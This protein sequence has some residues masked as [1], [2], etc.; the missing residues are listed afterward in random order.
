MQK[1]IL[2]MSRSTRSKT[3]CGR[4]R[5]GCVTPLKL[6]FLPNFHLKIFILTIQQDSKFDCQAALKSISGEETTAERYKMAPML[7][8]QQYRLRT[9]TDRTQDGRKDVKGSELVDAAMRH[10]V[11]SSN[12]WPS[13]ESV[14][15]CG[16][17]RNFRISWNLSNFLQT[18]N[19]RLIRNRWQGSGPR[20][21]RVGDLKR[22]FVSENF[23]NIL[24]LISKKNF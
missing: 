19:R 12:R 10:A 5:T 16:K 11:Q 24:K 4:V 2:I 9:W 20:L 8:P 18:T 3:G 6:I 17:F 23:K 1:L 22:G 13:S 15:S 14:K 7:S 21:G